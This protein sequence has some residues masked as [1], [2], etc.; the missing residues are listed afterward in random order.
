MKIRIRKP[1]DGANEYWETELNPIGRPVRDGRVITIHPVNAKDPIH[2]AI[3]EC[4]LD[5]FKDRRGK[6]K[7]FSGIPEGT[8]T[9]MIGETPFIIQKSSRYYINGKIMLMD[10]LC[11][12]LARVLFKSCFEK[13]PLKLMP[14][15]YQTTKLPEVVKYVVENRLPYW[16]YSDFTKHEVRLNVK[17]ISFDECAIEIGDGIWG[18]ITI[19][20][21]LKYANFYIDR[22]DNRNNNW[23]YTS[24]KQ[25]YHKLTG[26]IP[27]DSDLKVLIAFLKQNRKADIVEK[28]AYEL[29]QE[30][31]AQY[32]TKLRANYKKSK[33]QTL[34]VHGKKFDWKLEYKGNSAN[35]AV[36][37]Y[38]WQPE[39]N[40]VYDDDGNKTDEFNFGKCGW[41]GSI[42]IDNMGNHTPVGDQ[43]A[44]R[45]LALMNDTHTIKIVNTIN[46]YITD[47][48]NENRIDMDDL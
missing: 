23:K 9:L 43:F 15:L 2:Q 4:F 12:V 29:V 30:M 31:L 22:K 41:R 26:K 13:D 24:P 48:E 45:A 35:Q 20:E 1:H 34:Y 10:E 16:F 14:Y 39:K 38:I 17:Q 28:K 36:S 3:Y 42:C 47:N 6:Q 25:F 44:G 18:S 7:F 27:S 46:S 40:Y 32:P 21:L 11:H 8:T 19:K 5:S 33:L 37:T